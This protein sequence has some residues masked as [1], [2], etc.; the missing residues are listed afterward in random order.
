MVLVVKNLPAN[1]GVVRDTG[2][3][4]GQEDPSEEGMATHSSIPAWRIPWTE[5]PGGWQ[6]T[7]S[8][9]VGHNLVCKHV[10]CYT[11]QTIYKGILTEWMQPEPLL[12]P[13]SETSCISAT[14]SVFCLVGWFWPHW[15]SQGI[16]VPQPRMEPT[17]ATVEGR[18]LN[19]WSARK[20]PQ[21]N[22]YLHLAFL[23]W[24]VITT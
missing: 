2:S 5:E 4:P 19:H 13:F 24:A 16:L 14:S 15:A 12:T 21:C 7:A 3:I 1:A 9:R 11:H 17:L 8:H 18:S 10:E 6:S 22:Y 23:A 20:V